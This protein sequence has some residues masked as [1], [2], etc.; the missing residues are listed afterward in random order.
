[1]C[2][3]KFTLTFHTLTKILSKVVL[4]IKMQKSHIVFS[5][6]SAALKVGHRSR[7][8]FVVSL[9]Q[10]H[11]SLHTVHVA[12]HTKVL[13]RCPKLNNLKGSSLMSPVPILQQ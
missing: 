6:L 1:M 3:Q 11:V 7:S 10:V 8:I 9:S 4:H 12:P 5:E 2:T 13:A